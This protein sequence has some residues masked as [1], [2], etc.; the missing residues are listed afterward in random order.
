MTRR[1]STL[2]LHKYRYGE[3][4]PDEHAEIEQLLASDAELR[5]RLDAQLAQRSSF[6]DTP[7]PQAIL[8][9]AK[10][11]E[12]ANNNSAWMW[13]TAALVVAAMALIAV[14]RSAPPSLPGAPAISSD[15]RLKGDKNGIE[16][17][18]S[19]QDGPRKV[20]SDAPLHPGDRI[21]VRVRRP[22]A[23]WVTVAGTGPSGQ[24]E[25][26]GSW[27]ADMF[28]GGWQS[29][30]FALGLDDT[31]GAQAIHTVFSEQRPSESSVR[32]RVIARGPNIR[33]LEYETE[34]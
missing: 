21:Q 26:Y 8:D 23:P 20:L 11:P 9:L 34:E 33:T 19:T 7:I 31:L 14:P 30:P 25:I 24:V 4:S 28:E 2:T 13:M 18:V 16:A 1:V 29:A 5:A 10:A 3:L 15:V 22:T 32:A 17:W 6:E 12:P 27:E